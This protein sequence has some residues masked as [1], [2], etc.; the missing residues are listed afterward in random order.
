MSYWGKLLGGMAGFAMGGPLG[1]VVGAAL[2]HGA[3]QGA[4]PRIGLGGDDA[5]F[6]PARM[7]ALLAG[8]AEFL[9]ST[10]TLPGVAERVSWWR[11]Y[12]LAP[13]ITIAALVYVTWTN[14]LDVETG[15]PALL[16]TALQ[17]AVAGGYYWFA[18]RR[19][20]D[21]TVHVPD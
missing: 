20:G 21:W 12:P 5:P 11:L 14:W 6:G 8:Y 18:L 7:A 1:A 2:G 15:R 17:I 4:L 10:A 3:D 13:L 9:E 16:A 19:R